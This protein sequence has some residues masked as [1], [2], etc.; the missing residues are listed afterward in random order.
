MKEVNQPAFLEAYR[1]TGSIR[2]AAEAV[3]INR[4]THYDWLSD[5]ETYPERFQQAKADAAERLEEEARRRA[6]EGV[7]EQTGWWK[8][9]PGGTVRR[10]SDT[11]LIFLLKGALPA[12]YRER[13]EHTGAD[14]APL[15]TEI[16][17]VDPPAE[18]DE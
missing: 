9:K 5:D 14:G 18:A 16:V 6:V 10:Y 1:Q 2:A 4:Q 17:F 12:K 11:L 15:R 13:H 8:G 7:E 3:G